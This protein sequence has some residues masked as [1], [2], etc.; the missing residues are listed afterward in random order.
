MSC[1]RTN[2]LTILT[3]IG[4]V[5]GSVLGIILRSTRDGTW[6]EREVVYIQFVGDL[7]LRIL[8]GLVLPLIVST[9][10][11]AIGT[12]DLS[13]SGKMARV[14]GIYYV[15]TTTVAIVLG[16]V[17]AVTIKPGANRS[18]DSGD[19]GAEI[20]IRNVTTVDTLLDL[21]R[22]MFPPNYVQ[23][24]TQQYQTVLTAPAGYDEPDIYK[25]KMGEDYVDSMNIIGCVVAAVA[26][27]IAISSLK[28]QAAHVQ[29]FINDFSVII[30]KITSWVIWLSPIGVL[31]LICA[32]LIEIDDLAVLVG[33][34]GL[35][36]V[37]VLGG[38]L[39]HGFVIL[40]LLYFLATRKNPYI[41]VKNMGQAVATAFG[42]SSSSATLPVTIRCMEDFQ[43]LDKRV[44]RFIL[45]IGATINMDGTALY[46]ATAAIFISQLRGMSLSFGQVIAVAITATAASIGAA[47]IPQ[48]GLVTMVMVLDTIGLPAEDVSLIIAVDWLLDRF[49][50]VVNIMG[51]AFGAGIIAHYARDELAQK[52]VGL[53][54]SDQKSNANL[55]SVND[56]R[57]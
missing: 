7:F 41:L 36:F 1:M 11:A 31:F 29:K 56:V 54:E 22:N 25:W 38:I 35:Y 2:L 5:V 42:T 19:S 52:E 15:I 50:T 24:C 26:F 4:V 48:A 13:V 40:P 28:E 51:D 43:G 46:E 44:T 23:A 8:K 55:T 49:R 47:G 57:L 33:Q 12:L 30:M 17:L 3:L 9:L 27:G 6:T 34:L 20:S 18:G 21:V 32:K 53:E 10:I 39:F 16:I 37:T 14:G 45:P